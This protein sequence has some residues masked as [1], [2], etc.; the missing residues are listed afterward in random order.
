MLN[1]LFWFEDESPGDDA[2][3]SVLKDPSEEGGLMILFFLS[4]IGVIDDFRKAGVFNR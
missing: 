1:V 3:F 2:S 4:K